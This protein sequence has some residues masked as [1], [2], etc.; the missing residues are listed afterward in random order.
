MRCA[1]FKVLRNEHNRRNAGDRF[2]YFTDWGARWGKVKRVNNHRDPSSRSNFAPRHV[3]KGNNWRSTLRYSINWRITFL[4]RSV[5]STHKEIVLYV[6]TL[7]CLS[8]CVVEPNWRREEEEKDKKRDAERA[9]VKSE[10]NVSVCQVREWERDETNRLKYRIYVCSEHRDVG[11]SPVE[12]FIRPPPLAWLI[13]YVSSLTR[14]IVGIMINVWI[15]RLTQRLPSLWQY[16]DN[17]RGQR[18][19]LLL[20]CSHWGVKNECLEMHCRKWLRRLRSFQKLRT[21]E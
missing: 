9:T 19:F 3:S 8:V 10:K 16:V 13:I 12:T 18:L 20:C 17:D 2:A 4:Q 5:S 14:F 21:A 7:G 15:S 6:Y 1:C 11:T